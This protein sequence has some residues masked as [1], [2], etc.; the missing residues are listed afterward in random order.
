[1]IRF[2]PLPDTLE[3]DL[4]EREHYARLS[5]ADGCEVGVR[6]RRYVSANLHND[7][8]PIRRE[9]GGVG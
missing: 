4:A 9:V 2:T 7:L 5:R 1:M 8:R 3:R 6:A